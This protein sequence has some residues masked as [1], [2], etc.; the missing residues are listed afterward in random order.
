MHSYGLARRAWKRAEMRRTEG[1]R[2]RK[3]SRESTR[4]ERGGQTNERTDVAL[5]C[6]PKTPESW[7]GVKWQI[8]VRKLA[9]QSLREL[10]D[11]SCLN[12]PSPPRQA[13]PIFLPLRYP[14]R[15]PKPS[16]L[17]PPPPAPQAPPPSTIPPRRS[18]RTFH[19]AVK[20]PNGSAERDSARS[21]NARDASNGWNRR[22]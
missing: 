2:E 5:V 21:S 12:V 11:E 7:V 22:R 9:L 14:H 3:R 17:R 10:R 4:G 20:A 8:L 15:A 18:Y 19:S 16:E 6:T 13:A 1:K